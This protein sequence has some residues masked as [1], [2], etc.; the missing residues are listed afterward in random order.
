MSQYMGSKNGSAFPKV[1]L[2][3]L[4]TK[5]GRKILLSDLLLYIKLSAFL[6]SG[7]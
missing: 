3:N 5:L 6:L 7:Y 4:L 1:A 2:L